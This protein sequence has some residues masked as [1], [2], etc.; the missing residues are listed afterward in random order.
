MYTPP[1][2]VAAEKAIAEAWEGMPKFEGP[3]RVDL[4]FAVD[5]TSI[6]ITPVDLMDPITKP[7]RGDID[8]YMKTVL[9][10]LNGVAW[11]DDIQVVQVTAVKL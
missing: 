5:G 1:K 11:D 6:T 9:D 3:V 8:N 7:L 4:S 10:G 2:T